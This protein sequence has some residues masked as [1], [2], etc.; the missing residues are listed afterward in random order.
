MAHEPA[1]CVGEPQLVRS[2]WANGATALWA[3]CRECGGNISTEVGGNGLWLPHSYVEN[4]DDVP[5]V[6]DRCGGGAGS[7]PQ[8]VELPRGTWN[9]P[10]YCISCDEGLSPL[11]DG[12]PTCREC[13]AH[14]AG[15]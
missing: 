15:L 7:A 10:M 9:E 12:R 8:Q 6:E 14:P 11:D 3:R 2:L 13:R 5:L 1:R 4:I